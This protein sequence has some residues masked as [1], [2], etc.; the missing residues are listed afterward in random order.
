MHFPFSPY[1][2]VHVLANLGLFLMGSLSPAFCITQADFFFFF[3]KRVWEGALV[4]SCYVTNHST[5]SGLKG[6]SRICSQFCESAFG[7]SSWNSLSLLHGHQLSSLF[8]CCQPSVD[9]L[10]HLP[11]ALSWV[12]HLP[13]D[14][15]RLIPMVPMARLLRSAREASSMARFWT[16]SLNLVC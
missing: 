6:Q 7:L 8:I 9:G 10:I 14:S 3:R 11:R 12:P 2:P 5:L 16:L 4:S 1:F 15:P 13:E